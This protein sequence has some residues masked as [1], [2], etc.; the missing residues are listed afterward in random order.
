V[1]A[2]APAVTM[3]K[4]TSLSWYLWSEGKLSRKVSRAWTHGEA[5]DSACREGHVEPSVK[6]AGLAAG[7]VP[8]AGGGGLG[9]SVGGHHHAP[10]AGA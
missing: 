7:L 10:P 6:R 1:L 9:V 5:H 4:A 3:D 8:R 2:A